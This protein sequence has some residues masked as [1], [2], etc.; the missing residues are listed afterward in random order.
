MK[1][2]MSTVEFKTW[3]EQAAL[4]KFR[5]SLRPYQLNK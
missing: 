2:N 4:A 3:E 5:Y 1:G